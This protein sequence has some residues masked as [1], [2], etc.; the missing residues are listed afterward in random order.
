MEATARAFSQTEGRAGL[1]LGVLPSSHSC[2]MPDNRK[3]YQPPKGYPNP[4]IDLA[5]RT[6]LHLSASEG[7]EISSRNHIIIL[8]ADIVIALPGGAGTRSEI[9]LTIEY[10]KPLIIFDPKGKWKEFEVSP[11]T[12]VKDI[13]GVILEM[14]KRIKY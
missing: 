13:D 6:H 4:Y 5:I 12:H 1:T 9:Q 14:Q 10:G 11:A 2:D 7:M 3:S 8:T